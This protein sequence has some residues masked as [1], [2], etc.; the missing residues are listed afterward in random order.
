VGKKALPNEIDHFGWSNIPESLALIVEQAL[1]LFAY[2]LKKK[3]IELCISF[4]IP[5]FDWVVVYTCWLGLQSK[6]LGLDVH[7]G[8]CQ[9]SV[10]M[11]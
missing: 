6:L 8:Y 1:I 10:I 4:Y 7:L 9:F 11:V 3:Q 2:E 5:A